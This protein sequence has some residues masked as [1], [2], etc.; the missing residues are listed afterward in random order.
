[1]EYVIMD[2]PTVKSDA[3]RAK[4]YRERRHADRRTVDKARY[5]GRHF[6]AVDG[7]GITIRSGLRKGSHDYVLLAA[8][9]HDPILNREGLTTA[10]C[11]MYLWANLST[12]DIN[13]IYGGSY[14]FNC[15]VADLPRHMLEKLWSNSRKPQHYAGFDIRWL[16][17]K[18]FKISR[19]GK[20]IT[21]YDI[22]SFFQRPFIDACDEYLGE[23]EGRKILAREKARRSVFTWKEISTIGAYNDLE[24]RLLVRLAGELRKRLDDV[25][26]RPRQWI[27][28]GAIAAAL[29]E[30]ESI[31][32]H[33]DRNIP[34]PVAEASRYAY[35]GGR[36]ECLKYGIYNSSVWEYD[37]NSAYPKALSLVPSLAGGTWKHTGRG[38]KIRP[39]SFALYLIRWD[40]ASYD[41]IPIPGPL[42][43]R[44]ANGTI[45]YPMRGENWIWT[46][47]AENM[48]EYVE[49]F[50]G[51]YTVLEAWTFTPKSKHL[52]FGFLPAMYERRKVLKT[53]G[54]GAH[55]ALKL[56]MNSCYGKC[57]Q[58]VGW[59]KK[60]RQP[61]KYHQLEWA[62]F[63][64]SY[65]RAQVLKAAMQSPESIIAFETDAVFSMKPL[66]L[67]TSDRLGEWEE[68]EFD[69]LTYVQSGH[70]YGTESSTKQVMKCRG[71]DR[72]NV[73]RED[74]E[75][76]MFT[77]ERTLDA[78]LTRFM[79]I[80]IS[81][82][83]DMSL[84]RHWVTT[85]KT[86][87]LY[88]LGKRHPT[89]GDTPREHGMNRTWCP[90]H[91]E[92][93][94]PYPVEWINPD[95]NMI[96]LAEL[97]EAVIEYEDT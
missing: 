68:T 74:V 15:W 93:S 60:T 85:T 4:S 66:D 69:N 82:R 86:M 45:S 37:L 53:A 10:E 44:A 90:V 57:A 87:H 18:W 22:V 17:G 30:R 42:F 34:A 49:R 33:M 97:R 27:G 95:P 81:L 28:P 76:A 24:L 35:A 3:E 72:G 51:K 36:F 16:K 61:P 46:P 62:G 25:G 5:L 54:D 65:C 71:I 21:V 73:S 79:G 7:E 29:F 41:N 59:D 52:P 64:T 2:A 12:A 55:I 77:G 83:Q 31:P 38:S 75:R 94:H 19:A 13:V 40:T 56:A 32:D 11:L 50:G 8:S 80:G 48:H 58:Q 88:P 91:G 39:G 96:E 1:M 14:D 23:Y 70:Y 20:T 67:P 92:R 43:V 47:E 9:G 26:L 63:A 78:P 6:V 89:P 84:W